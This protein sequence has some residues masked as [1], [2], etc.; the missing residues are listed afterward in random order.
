MSLGILERATGIEP[1]SLAWK[2][3]VLPLHNARTLSAGHKSGVGGGQGA[4]VQE[5]W[6]IF[7]KNGKDR[8]FLSFRPLVLRDFNGFRTQRRE[9]YPFSPYFCLAD[10]LETL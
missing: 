10:F 4:L 5:S 2:A 8:F 1:V 6:N 7:A 3:R 9:L